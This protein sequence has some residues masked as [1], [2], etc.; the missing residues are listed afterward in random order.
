MQQFTIQS[1]KIRDKLNSLLPSQNVGSIGVELTGSTQIVPIV[2]LTEIA[3]G[4]SLRQDLQTALDFATDF[5]SVANTTTTLVTTTGFYRVFGVSNI[6]NLATGTNTLFLDDGSSTKTLFQDSTND[7]SVNRP[8][9]CTTFDFITFLSAGISLKGT[10]NG[11]AVI[12]NVGTRQVA[13]LS[14]N[15]TNPIGFS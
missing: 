4:S 10:S 12:L 13:D 9:T 3:E 1:E 8:T 6:G 14:G 7:N 11:T 2:D 15:L 5:N